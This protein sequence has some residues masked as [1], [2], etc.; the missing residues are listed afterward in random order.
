M[1]Q[2]IEHQHILL[3]A[4]RRVGKTSLLFKMEADSVGQ[5]DL[6]V[7]Y[8]SAAAVEDELAFVDKIYR[9]VA[10][11]QGAEKVLTY[12]HQGRLARLFKGVHSFRVS[13]LEVVFKEAKP[14]DWPE[15]GR[16]LARSLRK[17]SH[18]WVLLVDELPLLVL[19]LCRADP[20]AARA[21]TCLQRFR[22]V[23]QG[24]SEAED[25]IHW[26]LAGS[27]GLDT[28]AR[29]FGLGDTINDLRLETLGPFTPEIADRFLTELGAGHSIPL[30]PEVRARICERAGW[31]IPYHLQMLFSALRDRCPPRGRPT[32]QMVDDA[33]ETLLSPG[34]R[35]YFDY[36][37]QRLGE[38]L[39]RPDSSRAIDLLTA[40][41]RAVAGSPTDELRQVLGQH[42]SEPEERDRD[43]I[44]L[45]DILVNDGYLV[46]EQRQ[47]R[48]RSN[49]L[50]ESWKRRYG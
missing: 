44:W 8:L 35:A 1:W 42:V 12:L 48:F 36:W 19:A 34:Y 45:L 14:D 6:N 4:P 29:R 9:A 32:V 28:V 25:R 5:K 21:R 38:E 3:L 16:E 24:T 47:F 27:I 18:R 33:F 13:E 49:L 46:E 30:E 22:D 50:R 10:A 15:L 31:L 41:A 39:G 17:L 2:Q 20:R 40:C 26:V 43:L 23:R 7:I 11:R 37:I